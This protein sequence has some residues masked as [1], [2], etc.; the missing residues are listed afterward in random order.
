MLERSLWRLCAETLRPAQDPGFFNDQHEPKEST[1]GLLDLDIP[2][3]MIGLAKQ[4]VKLGD[5]HRVGYVQDTDEE[6][7]PDAPVPASATDDAPKPAPD[8]G[9][10]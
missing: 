2:I 1:M 3:N 10:K 7:A 9:S 4:T 5:A 8:G 6:S